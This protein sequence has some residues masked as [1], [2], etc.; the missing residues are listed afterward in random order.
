MAL[1]QTDP[2]FT[3]V[4]CPDQEIFGVK[5]QL[6]SPLHSQALPEASYLLQQILS[7]LSQYEILLEKKINDERS[8]NPPQW[9]AA[10]TLSAISSQLD[11]SIKQFDP[12]LQISTFLSSRNLESHFPLTSEELGLAVSMQKE[13]STDVRDY[14]QMTAFFN[15]IWSMSVQIQRDIAARVHKYIAHQIALL[16]QSLNQIGAI[17]VPYKKRI[18]ERFEE[19]KAALEAPNSPMLNEGQCRWLADLCADICTFLSTFSPDV[20]QKLEP[21]CSVATA[22]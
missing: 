14:I 13:G 19:I 6:D 18:E 2:L 5:I 11:E 20:R 15:Q 3:P 17:A 21:F 8:E 22:N 12:T 7:L 1:R 16:Y 4:F 9:S 10:P